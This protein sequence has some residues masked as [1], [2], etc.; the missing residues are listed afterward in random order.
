V[1]RPDCP[2]AQ[3]LFDQVDRQHDSA[4]RHLLRLM[5]QARCP[6]VID[7]RHK[8]AYIDSTPAGS[9]EDLDG[10]MPEHSVVKVVPLTQV[11]GLS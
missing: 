4:K 8:C 3:A 2:E 10:L 5:R 6:L 9:H 11:A 1:D 7:A